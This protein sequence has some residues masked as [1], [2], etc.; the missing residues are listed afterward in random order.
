MPGKY[1][2]YMTNTIRARTMDL[3]FLLKMPLQK[4]NAIR[5]YTTPLAPI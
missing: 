2:L 1:P 4:T 3:K 5:P